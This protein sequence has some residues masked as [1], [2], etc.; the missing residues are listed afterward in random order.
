MGEEKSLFLY[1]IA[2]SVLGVILVVIFTQLAIYLREKWTKGAELGTVVILKEL[3]TIKLENQH[4]QELIKKDLENMSKDLKRYQDQI[5]LSEKRN[6]EMEA[7]VSEAIK[8]SSEALAK[9]KA[10]EKLLFQVQKDLLNAGI[11]TT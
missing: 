7:K 4:G 2:W 10:N 3:N 1:G 11:K 9:S 8:T 6:K 5:D